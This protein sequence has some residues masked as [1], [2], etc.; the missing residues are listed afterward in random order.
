MLVHLFDTFKILR[1]AL[2]NDKATIRMNDTLPGTIK[3][4]AENRIVQVKSIEFGGKGYP[5]CTFVKLYNSI[6][7]N[8]VSTTTFNVDG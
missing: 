7:G 4:G 2:K 8:P 3:Y 6:S 1:V 5:S